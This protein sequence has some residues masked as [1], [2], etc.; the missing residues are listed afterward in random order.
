MCIRGQILHPTCRSFALLGR[1]NGLGR[2]WTQMHTESDLRCAL[3]IKGV[4]GRLLRVT[5]R[6]TPK[7][8]GTC[9]GCCPGWGR[10]MQPFYKRV[11]VVRKDRCIGCGLCE[12]VCPHDCLDVR[13]RIGALVRPDQCRSEGAC[14][15]ACPGSALQMRWL[16]LDGNRLLGKW[17]GRS[18][19]QRRPREAAE[20][21]L[22]TRR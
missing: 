7:L 12:S 13:C 15:S 20:P 3:W 5:K 1:L 18:V 16:K 2:G 6:D 21:A 22:S 14:V 11:P 8:P 4:K 17:R 9:A 19:S 10:G